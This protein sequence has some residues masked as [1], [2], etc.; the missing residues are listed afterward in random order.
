MSLI[1][2]PSGPP[3]PLLHLSAN[4]S[5]P[6]PGV[7]VHSEDPPALGTPRAARSQ[8]HHTPSPCTPKPEPGKAGDTFGKRRPTW[9]W[10]E[11]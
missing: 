4:G 1:P 10:T 6:H 8:E 7:T 11:R 9:L 2:W 5:E 3:Q